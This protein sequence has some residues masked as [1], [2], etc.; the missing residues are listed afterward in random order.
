MG[1]DKASAASRQERGEPQAPFTLP[2]QRCLPARTREAFRLE[3]DPGRQT[4]ENPA[5]DLEVARGDRFRMVI[6]T[7]P[8]SGVR[9]AANLVFTKEKNLL[10]LTSRVKK[11]FVIAYHYVQPTCRGIINEFIRKRAISLQ[12]WR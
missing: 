4:D 3:G 7:R 9:S 6:I 1:F 2:L 5:L 10:F 8:T 12:I 11:F